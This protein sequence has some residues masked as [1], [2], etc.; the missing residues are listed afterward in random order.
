MWKVKKFLNIIGI[1]F[2]IRDLGGFIKRMVGIGGS[3]SIIVGIINWLVENVPI[4]SLILF[5]GGIFL[6]GMAL[7]PNIS[8]LITKQKPQ[9][10]TEIQ[11]ATTPHLTPKTNNMLIGWQRLFKTMCVTSPAV[12]PIS[13]FISITTARTSGCL[14]SH[15]YSYS[16]PFSF[17]IK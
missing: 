8:R 12:L 2:D 9:V 4:L 6:L 17:S 7:F 3:S 10:T 5:G 11:D 14:S 13:E 15:A 16:I 1:W